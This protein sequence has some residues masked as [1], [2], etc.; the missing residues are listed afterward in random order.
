VGLTVGVDVGGTKI[1]SGVVDES[2]AVLARDEVPTPDPPG[3]DA[4]AIADVIGGEIR[5]L[6]AEHEVE[7]VGIGAAGFVDKQRAVV[8]F[9]P[10]I[11]WRDEPLRDR[12]Q[13]HVDIPVVVENDANA[14]AW[15]EFRFGA[16]EDVDDLVLLTVGT[17]IG[18]GIVLDGELYRGAFGVAAEVGHLRV[19]PYGV[20]CGCGNRGCW[21]QY[22]SGRALVRDARQ[23][24]LSATPGSEALAAACGGEA[25]QLDGPTVTRL[26]QEG[27]AA[28]VGI[29]AEVGRWLGEGLASLA[30]VLDPAVTV[31]GGGV[32]AAGDLLLDPMQAA[33]ESHLTARGYRPVMAIRPAQLGNDAGIVGA[34]DLARRRPGTG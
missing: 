30:A 21:E 34:A 14:A 11:D 5:A 23:L 25:E 33:F 19:V 9:A 27:D 16:G 6:C 26:A 31:V 32:S 1:A 4:K 24:V 12:V 13:A 20:L 18:G 15:A 28:C 22:G 29:V 7:A 3:D 10:N 17:G 2:G 8:I